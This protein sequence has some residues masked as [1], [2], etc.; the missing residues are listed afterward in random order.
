VRFKIS[1]L[2]FIF[3]SKLDEHLLVF[4]K[5]QFVKTT[6]S[7]SFQLFSSYFKLTSKVIFDLINCIVIPADDTYS[8]LKNKPTYLTW[9]KN[10][11]VFT[12]IQLILRGPLVYLWFLGELNLT[13]RK[14]V[15]LNSEIFFIS[16]T[17]LILLFNLKQLYF[18]Q[19]NKI[20]ITQEKKD[21]KMI[22]R[23]FYNMGPQFILCIRQNSFKCE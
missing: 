22:D 4:I 2:F 10:P 21:Y 20:F 11:R 8:I 14:I 13:R 5:K 18:N 19:Y 15:G 16:N 17:P 23:S 3:K 6:G 7:K 12:I 1:F 9:G